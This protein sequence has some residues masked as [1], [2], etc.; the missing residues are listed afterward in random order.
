MRKRVNNIKHYVNHISPKMLWGIGE[1][2]GL[3]KHMI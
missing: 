2:D 3:S 1:W